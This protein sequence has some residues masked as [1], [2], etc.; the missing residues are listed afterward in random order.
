MKGLILETSGDKGCILLSNEGKVIASRSLANGAELSKHIAQGVDTLLKE[1][2]F[3]PDFIAIGTGPGSYTGLRVG[4]ALGRALGFGWSLPIFGFC[5]MR[6]FAPENKHSFALLLDAKGNGIYLLT[7][8]T[9]TPTL[10]SPTEIPQHLSTIP[11]ISSP[12]PETIQKRVSIT[13]P[14][15]LAE[16]DLE[17]LT[18]ETYATFL[19]KDFPPVKLFL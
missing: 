16:I 8:Q 2:V 7:N 10:L 12:H 9:T 5:S 1:W 17:R 13:Q 14:C 18:K 15:H 4:A 3:H 11:H 6:A 19:S